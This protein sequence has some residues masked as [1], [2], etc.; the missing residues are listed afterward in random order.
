M[1]R[2]CDLVA[3][4]THGPKFPGEDGDAKKFKAGSK[5]NGEDAIEKSVFPEV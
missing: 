1:S 3:S 4:G 2:L 5:F